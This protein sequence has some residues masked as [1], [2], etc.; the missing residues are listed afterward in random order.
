[1]NGIVLTSRHLHNYTMG[2]STTSSLSVPGQ[3]DVFWPTGETTNSNQFQI[4]I[5]IA[6]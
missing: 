2:I 6:K 4:N 1:M 3:Q 5:I